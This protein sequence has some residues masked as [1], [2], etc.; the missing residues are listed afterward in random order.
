M[1]PVPVSRAVVI[2]TCH[3][4]GEDAKF[5]SI[6][7]TWDNALPLYWMC[8]YISTTLSKTEFVV[9]GVLYE[10]IEDLYNYLCVYIHRP[11]NRNLRAMLPGNPG[12]NLCLG[13]ANTG[14]CG[15]PGQSCGV[16]KHRYRKTLIQTQ[17]ISGVPQLPTHTTICPTDQSF[18]QA[19]FMKNKWL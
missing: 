1:C 6:N 3:F 8:V 13:R 18:S 9:W 12:Q 2:S 16:Y 11:S 5:N 7:S 4:W 14:W 10:I 15:E 19:N 17:Q